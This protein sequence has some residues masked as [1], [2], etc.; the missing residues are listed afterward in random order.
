MNEGQLLSPVS[1]KRVDTSSTRRDTKWNY[2]VIIEIPQGKAPQ[3]RSALAK[4]KLSNFQYMFKG[5]Y[6]F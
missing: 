6:R 3:S 5:I 4:R 2:G 1:E